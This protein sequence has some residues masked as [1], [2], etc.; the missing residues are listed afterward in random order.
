MKLDRNDLKGKTLSWALEQGIDTKIALLQHY[1]HL[2]CLL[3]EEI[4]AE[5]VRLLAGAP[6]SRNK[7]HGGRYS[8]WGSNIRDRFGWSMRKFPL[9]YSVFMTT[10]SEVRLS[11]R[12]TAN[13]I[14]WK[15]RRILL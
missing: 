13:F 12:P 4:M 15:R 3:A 2:G 14:R 7:P 8:R 10:R 1:Q 9:R 11:R 6:Y 5:E